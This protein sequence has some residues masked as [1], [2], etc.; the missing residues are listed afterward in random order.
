MSKV[1]LIAIHPEW[2][3]AIAERRKRYDLVERSESALFLSEIINACRK[4]VIAM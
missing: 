3:E 1:V 2:C 4:T